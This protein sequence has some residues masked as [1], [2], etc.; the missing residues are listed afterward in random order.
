MSAIDLRKE[1]EAIVDR[2]W[3]RFKVNALAFLRNNLPTSGGTL[4]NDGNG[5]SG[6]LAGLNLYA[7]GT[8]RNSYSEIDYGGWSGMGYGHVKSSALVTTSPYAYYYANGRRNSATYHGYDFIGQTKRDLDSQ[9]THI[10]G[11]GV[12]ER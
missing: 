1:Y 3:G 4:G 8:L 9:Y 11:I 12:W 10:T 5:S 6:S 2:E 7:T